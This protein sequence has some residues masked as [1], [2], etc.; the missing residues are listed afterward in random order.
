MIG[1]RVILRML[2][3]MPWTDIYVKKI[4]ILMIYQIS[5]SRTLDSYYTDQYSSYMNTPPKT[6]DNILATALRLFAERGYE[7]VGVAEICEQ[8]GITKPSLYHHFCSKRGLLDAIIAERGAPLLA[9]VR[10]S[11][12]DSNDVP[13]SLEEMAFSMTRAAVADRDFA[14]LRL[15]L[16]FAPPAS[17]G[18]AAAATF[19]TTLFEELRTYFEAATEHH[20]NMR[21]RSRAYAATFIGTIDSYVGFFLADRL[22]LDEITVRS[23]VRQFMY[24]IFS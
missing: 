3:R 20:G 7:A 4:D 11:L 8:S 12:A 2:E 22:K 24:G 15:G 13:R 21:G 9:A 14:R 17:E 18:G 10:G 6:R 16:A 5:R 23:A 1:C 19:N